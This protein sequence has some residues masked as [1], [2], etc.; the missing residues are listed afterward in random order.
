[1]GLSLIVIRFHIGFI[2]GRI[3]K[4]LVSYVDIRC[5]NSKDKKKL[6]FEFFIAVMRLKQKIVVIFAHEWKTIVLLFT[7]FSSLLGMLR[8]CTYSNER[9]VCF[10]LLLQYY[11]I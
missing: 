6:P 5:L 1:M 8:A 9:S 4:I 3:M 2:A 10:E 11:N 7:N